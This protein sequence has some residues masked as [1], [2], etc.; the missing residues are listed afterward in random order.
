MAA[1]NE[2][3]GAMSELLLAGHLGLGDGL[4][5]NAIYRRMASKY[6]AV[7]VLC[8]PH[9]NSTL[10]FMVRDVVNMEMFSVKNDDEA[11]ECIK[12][13]ATSGFDVLKLGVFSGEPFDVKQWDKEFYRQADIPFQERWNGFI[14]R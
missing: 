8:K 10:S 9:N 6:D 4:L 14:Q 2:L 5:S 11:R 13:S 1:Q 7:V 12:A 3:D